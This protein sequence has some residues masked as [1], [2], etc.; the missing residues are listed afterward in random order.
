MTCAT[1]GGDRVQCVTCSR[2]QYARQLAAADTREK[3]LLTRAQAAE[4]R[5]AAARSA[6]LTADHDALCLALG[7]QRITTLAFVRNKPPSNV[8]CDVPGCPDHDKE[9]GGA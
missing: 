1:C 4:T 2:E 3:L 9:G 6:V 7:F 5:L 8:E